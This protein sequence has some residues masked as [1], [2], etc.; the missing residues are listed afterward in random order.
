MSM[1][2]RQF[3]LVRRLTVIQRYQRV[4]AATFL[5]CMRLGMG[6]QLTLNE[7]LETHSNSS[8]NTA[9]NLDAWKRLEETGRKNA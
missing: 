8:I 4:V 5:E 9:S 3:G 1:S 6:P 2:K 7:G